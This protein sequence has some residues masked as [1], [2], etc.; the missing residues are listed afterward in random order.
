MPTTIKAESF[1]N[2]TAPA[3]PAGWTTDGIATT[4]ASGARSAPNSYVGDAVNQSYNYWPA[5]DGN[6]GDAQAT[7]WGKPDRGLFPLIRIT[8]VP[9]TAGAGTMYFATLGGSASPQQARLFKRVAGVQTQLSSTV[10]PSPIFDTAAYHSV[11]A[12][13]NG[14]T[15]SVTIIR[16]NGDYLTSS[17]AWS[18]TPQAAITVTDAAITGQGYAGCQIANLSVNDDF[19]YESLATAATAATT[20]SG[21][22]AS[23]R[24][25]R[26][27]LMK[28]ILYHHSR[29]Q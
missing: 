5:L 12:T 2:V 3:Q 13:A 23:I 17:G 22:L 6:G 26:R 20:G 7:M 10:I 21:W 28:R 25:Q 8:A 1:D 15:I 4:A 16:P 29:R 24:R 14:T 9:I 11:T 18:A 19:L 27:E